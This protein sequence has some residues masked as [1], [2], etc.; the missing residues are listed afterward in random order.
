[1]SDRL[2]L[3]TT[4]FFGNIVDDVRALTSVHVVALTTNPFGSQS[5]AYES[6]QVHYADVVSIDFASGPTMTQV[7][8]NL[9]APAI[10]A[11][12]PMKTSGALTAVFD[13]KTEDINRFTEALKRRGLVSLDSV[14]AFVT[15]FLTEF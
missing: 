7:T 5:D 6:L 11:E 9:S 8:V 12:A 10:V 3:D 14:V 2:Y 15:R 13:I 4:C 1:M